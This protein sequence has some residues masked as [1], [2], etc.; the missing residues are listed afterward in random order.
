MGINVRSKDSLLMFYDKK[1]DNI[2]IEKD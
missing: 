2:E 1:K